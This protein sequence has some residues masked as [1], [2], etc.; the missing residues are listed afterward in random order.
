MN[1]YSILEHRYLQKEPR[2]CSLRGF[3]PLA[4][5]WALAPLL[6]FSSGSRF[7]I[8]ILNRNLLLYYSS[9]IYIMA[10]VLYPTENWKYVW[11]GNE[12]TSG[13]TTDSEGNVIASL[14]NVDGELIFTASF[15]VNDE[16]ILYEDLT[17]GDGEISIVDD[18]MVVLNTMT[19][20]APSFFSNFEVYV[21]DVNGEYATYSIN[22]DSV[23]KESVFLLSAFVPSS[24]NFNKSFISK[25]GFRFKRPSVDKNFYFK[26]FD[27]HTVYRI[28]PQYVEP[29]E[30]IEFLGMYDNKGNTVKLTDNSNPTYNAVAKRI[31]EA[32]AYV[33]SQCRRAWI[34]KRVVGEIRNA[35]SA[36][37]MTQSYLG[38]FAPS[39]AVDNGARM[40]FTG[41][42]VKLIYDNIQ[43]L[44]YSK[45]DR[46][47][48]RM[49]GTQWRSIP[50]N[51]VWCDTQK[52]IIYVKALC[53]QRDASVKVTYRYGTGPC[54]PDIRQAVILKTALIIVGT[55]WYRQRFPQS[56]MFDPL[57]Q[58]TITSWTWSLKD[59]LKNYTSHV[60]VG[61][62]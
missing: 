57:K 1:V 18:N 48:I 35:D 50:E 20:L 45:G 5:H 17:A 12:A 54:P 47:E 43:P 33:E 4:V 23:G 29:Q 39:E 40:F 31:V 6:Y 16:V 25:F 52:G 13:E 60:E 14:Q 61:G 11:D 59:I 46:V 9:I 30:V 10:T 32:E 51:M 58:E 41:I 42:P 44:D 38:I 19:S 22:N 21:E 49:Y 34:E 26:L 8:D 15:G 7:R 28:Q 55:D 37:G 62:M 24:P 3:S 2:L 56:P 53:F 27:L 36:F